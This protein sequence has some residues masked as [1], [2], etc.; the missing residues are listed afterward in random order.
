MPIRS[1][2]GEYWHKQLNSK[3]RSGSSNGTR[4]PKYNYAYGTSLFRHQYKPV[5]R[6]VSLDIRILYTL[7]SGSWWAAE[8]G[9]FGI[10]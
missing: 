7:P 5:W 3:R 1:N 2:I 6:E 10:F 4:R 9:T 8:L